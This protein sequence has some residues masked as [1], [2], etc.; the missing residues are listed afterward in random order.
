MGCRGV[1]WKQGQFYLI[2]SEITLDLI[3]INEVCVCSPDGGGK[4]K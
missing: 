2:V 1:Q 4:E 3:L